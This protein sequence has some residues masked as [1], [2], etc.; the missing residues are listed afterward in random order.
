[1][2]ELERM[3]ER[4]IH[5]LIA[6]SAGVCN[7]PGCVE[8]LIYQ[9]E[10]G[11]FV[12]LVEFAHIIGESSEGPR[13]IPKKSE[14]LA[15]DPENIILLCVKHHR[16][17][18]NNTEQYPV[19]KLKQMKKDHIIWV[20]EK[21]KGLEDPTWTLIIH[22]GNVNGNNAPIIDKELIYRDFYGVHII[23][24]IEEYNVDEFLTK[25]KNWQKSMHKQEI[26]WSFIIKKN[27]ISKKF[28]ICSI[29]FIPLVIHL[30]Y[31]IHD[32]S[33][34]EIYQYQRQN[35]SWKWEIYDENYDDLI[36]IEKPYDIEN[37]DDK[38]LA[39]SISI[40]GVVNDDDII[41]NQGKNIKIYKIYVKNPDRTWLRYKEQLREF[42]IKYIKLI[43]GI[44]QQYKNLKEVH[45]FYAGPTPIA[46]IVGAHI[47]PT[48]HPQFIVYNYFS[49]EDPK[50]SEAL[51][52][53]YKFIDS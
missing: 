12:K 49:K 2:I 9:Y 37:F 42:Q 8:K 21:L 32:T 27:E 25:T 29:N 46:F 23:S 31:L 43:D 39:L 17:V 18:D 34:V 26:W 38:K 53:N 40:S 51:R 13:G 4:D 10:D 22:T 6:E 19:K 28:I 16:I 30:G 7:Y 36:L 24:D 14:L 41:I 52:I 44:V 5:R 3:K 45:L 15:Q 11:S 20:K 35:N 1:M 33:N 50:Y 47:T 48:I